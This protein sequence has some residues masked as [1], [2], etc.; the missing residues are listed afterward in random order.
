VITEIVGVGGM[1]PRQLVEFNRLAAQTAPRS[2]SLDSG[3]A[4]R[5]L[6]KADGYSPHSLLDELSSA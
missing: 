1:D 5:V 3:R 2:V 4:R 6:Q